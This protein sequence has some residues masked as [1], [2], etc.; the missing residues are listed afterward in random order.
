M[1]Y[2]L[3]DGIY[4]I[5]AIFVKTIPCFEVPKRSQFATMQVSVWKDVE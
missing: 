2:Y 3:A 1:G 4:P 5:W